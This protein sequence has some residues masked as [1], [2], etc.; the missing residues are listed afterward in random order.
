MPVGGGGPPAI[1][2]FCCSSQK[3]KKKKDGEK[4]RTF[5]AVTRRS[6]DLGFSKKK[7]RNKWFTD[8]Q[9]HTQ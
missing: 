1:F 2:V 7:K 8:T 5:G 3:K 6:L 9:T 4:S